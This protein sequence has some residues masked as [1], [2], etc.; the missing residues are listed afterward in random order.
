VGFFVH[1]FAGR[2]VLKLVFWFGLGF[3]L[4][5]VVVVQRVFDVGC[6]WLAIGCGGRKPKTLSI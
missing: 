6:G 2:L 1:N 5:V 4:V 3:V